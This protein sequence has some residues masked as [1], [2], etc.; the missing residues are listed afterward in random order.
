[1]RFNNNIW[2]TQHSSLLK[3]EHTSFKI[4]RSIKWSITILSVLLE[5]TNTYCIMQYRNAVMPFKSH[6]KSYYIG[7]FNTEVKYSNNPITTLCIWCT[8]CLFLNGFWLCWSRG[9]GG[10]ILWYLPETS[11]VFMRGENTTAF[12]CLQCSR[13]AINYNVL[14]LQRSKMNYS[15]ISFV[16]SIWAIL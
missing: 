4:R 15:L 13:W 2:S 5:C 1:M 3:S 9:G 10:V 8:S 12:S 7:L 14:T 11:V 6:N 16:I